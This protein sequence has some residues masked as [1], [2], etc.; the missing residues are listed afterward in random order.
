MSFDFKINFGDLEL[1]PDGD[2]VKV[3]KA[4]KLAQDLSKMV[5]T[6]KGSKRLF[7]FYGSLLSNTIVG[8]VF[9]E[10]FTAAY[11]SKQLRDCLDI[12]IKIQEMQQKNQ[13]L[14]PQEML[15]AIKQALVLQSDQDPR[16]WKVIIR[17]ITKALEDA[18]ME[19]DYEPP[20]I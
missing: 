6:P 18:N 3:Q 4:E 14:D 20:N 16:F 11:A 13:Y 17:V 1:G 12:Y 7:P 10:G 19:F 15:G 8:N 5:N 2:F 9:D